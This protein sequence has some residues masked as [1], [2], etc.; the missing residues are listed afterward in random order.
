[1]VVKRSLREG[2]FVFLGNSSLGLTTSSEVNLNLGVG[3]K[4]GGLLALVCGGAVGTNT[5]GADGTFELSL[6]FFV[7]LVDLEK[8]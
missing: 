3:V 7:G 6:F 1:M 5:A 2:L 4:G 8:I